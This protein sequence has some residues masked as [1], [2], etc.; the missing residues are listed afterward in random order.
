MIRFGNH[1]ITENVQ[2]FWSELQRG[3]FIIDA[4]VAAGTYR[5]QGTRWVIAIGCVRP[6]RGRDL[7]GRCV[8]FAGRE[9]IAMSG[10]AGESVR[11]I[12]TRLGGGPSTISRELRRNLGVGR[13]LSGQHG[14]CDGLPPRVAPESGEAGDG[15]GA[16]GG[17]GAGSGEEALTRADHLPGCDCSSPTTRRCG[18]HPRPSINRSTC[19][20]VARCAAIWRCVCVPAGRCGD[21]AARSGNAR[22]GSRT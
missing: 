4:A 5:K 10:A 1:M 6:R 22:T 18:C 15:H 8:S 2:V 17:G 21:P 13:R 12:A 16:A 20:L 9:Q 7:L 19:S 14:T 3:E 11:S